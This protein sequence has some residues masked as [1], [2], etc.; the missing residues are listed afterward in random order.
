MHKIELAIE[1]PGVLIV[2]PYGSNWFFYSLVHPL[3]F[4]S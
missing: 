4:V 3:D 2:F 1:L